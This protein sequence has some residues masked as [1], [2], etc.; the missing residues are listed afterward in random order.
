M[1]WL[2]SG[3][4]VLIFEAMQSAGPG[5]F[6]IGDRLDSVLGEADAHAFLVEVM[7]IASKTLRRAQPMALVADETRLLL[8]KRIRQHSNQFDLL[9]EHA[10]YCHALAQAVCDGV[11]LDVAGSPDA[12]RELA[13]RAKVWERRADHLVMQAR[14]Q[15]KR[16]PG[17][18]P[19]GNLM[20]L[21]DDVADALEEAAFL[22]SLIADGHRQGWSAEVRDALWQLADTVLFATQ[23]HVKSL[24]IAR[25]LSATSEARDSDAFL[26]ASWNV[27]RSE[28]KCDELLRAGR[29]IIL[30]AVT[31]APALMLANDLAMTLEL[32]SDRLLVAGY[33]LRDVAFSLTEVTP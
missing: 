8:A 1:A 25:S 32:A 31:D 16:Q 29:R 26:S 18:R 3:G 17:W 21:S 24:A 6:R 15:S 27:L 7:H 12:A 19:F 4:E 20:A 9:D 10:G 14:E 22:M 2:K 13:A 23:E 33:A 30:T 11:M 28:R 5:A